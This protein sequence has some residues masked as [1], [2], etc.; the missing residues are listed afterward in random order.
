VR[1]KRGDDLDKRALG[2]FQATGPRFEIMRPGKPSGGVG[3]PFRWPAK[4]RR[5]GARSDRPLRAHSSRNR[6]VRSP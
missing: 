4:A 5:S 3:L 2:L 1:T 6:L